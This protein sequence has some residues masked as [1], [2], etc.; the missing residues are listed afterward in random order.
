MSRWDGRGV[1]VRLTGDAES[2]R[3]AADEMEDEHDDG[4]DDEDVDEAARNVKGEAAD[5]EQ[6]QN[7]GNG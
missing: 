2:L 7:N 1:A 6:Q 3:A 4:Y 5:P